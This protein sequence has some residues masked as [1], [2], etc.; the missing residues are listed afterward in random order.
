MIAYIDGKLT[1]KSPTYV[2]IETYGVGY[3]IRISLN[4]YS[5][6][7]DSE[8]C[9]LHTYLHIKE[10][11]HTLFGF[12]EFAEKKLFLDLISISG[13]GPGTAVVVLS[14]L[15]PKEITEAIIG[16]DVKTIQS[17]KGIGAK[18]AQRIILE[19]KDKIKKENN[20]SE[21]SNLTTTK[22]NTV[23]DEALSALIMLGV[24]KSVAEKNLD[25]V[26]K[27]TGADVTL[28]DLIKHSL[29]IS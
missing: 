5:Q 25:I 19:L 15:S 20:S 9:K 10:D 22:R 23:K 7:T 16:E 8:R 24:T 21:T 14:Y 27:K 29:R 1:F 11:A 12:S 3:Q 6:I 26:L 2:I 13:V 17:I 4:T 18:T 28:E